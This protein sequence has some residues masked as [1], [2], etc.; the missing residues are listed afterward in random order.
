MRLAAP[1]AK[2]ERARRIVTIPEFGS[3]QEGF[4]FVNLRHT[5]AT[6]A[7]EAGAEPDPGGPS[8]RPHE[9]PDGRTALRREA[10]PRRQ[11]D[12]RGSNRV[13]TSRVFSGPISLPA[14]MAE[15]GS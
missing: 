13:S 11:G 6:L 9:Y 14:A 3:G 12:R 8:T 7:L 10:R 1:A 4:R 2:T 15:S 5:G